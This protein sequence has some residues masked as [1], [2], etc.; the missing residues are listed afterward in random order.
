MNQR[1]RSLV[2]LGAGSF[3]TVLVGELIGGLAAHAQ[4]S[5]PPV[6][7]GILLLASE[8]SSTT[9]LA[10]FTRGMRDNG[11]IEGRHYVLDVS[12]AQ[13]DNQRF[14]ALVKDLLQRAPAVIMTQSNAGTRAA[15][16]ATRTVPIVMFTASDPVGT[17]LVASLAQP[18]GNTTGLSNQS[19]DINVKFVEFVREALPRAK[20]IALLVNPRSLSASA[21]SEKVGAAAHRAGIETRSV[22]AATPAALDAAFAAIARLRPDVLLVQRESML[23]SETPRISAFALEN[24]IALFGSDAQFAEAGGLLSYG[25][26]RLDMYRRAAYFVDKILKG[27]KPADLPVEQP[28]KFE[29]VINLRT[30]RALGITI[31]QSVLLRADEVIR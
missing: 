31:P 12:Y 10:A 13:G 16:L 22:E 14:H 26:S 25:P 7:I 19:E 21:M 24:R 4:G 5:A 27:A 28:T 15:Q 8:T 30:A 2:V 17:G 6:R 9:R 20:R 11:L 29:L 3:A 1:R 18:G 23:N